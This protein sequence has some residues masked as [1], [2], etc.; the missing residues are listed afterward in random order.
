MLLTTRAQQNIFSTAAQTKNGDSPTGKS[1]S[2]APKQNCASPTLN[3]K[4][5]H[6]SSTKHFPHRHSNKKLQKTNRKL[7][8]RNSNKNC[9]RQ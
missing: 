2:T 9:A 7:R 3:K 6:A 8:Q 1:D 5:K 4:F